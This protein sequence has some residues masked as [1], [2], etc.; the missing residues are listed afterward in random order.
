MI[1]KDVVFILT[2]VNV[3]MLKINFSI[4]DKDME[5][6]KPRYPDYGRIKSLVLNMK[7]S[8]NQK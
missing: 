7:S 6:L 8:Y 2:L 3:N 4:L 1:Y 5:L